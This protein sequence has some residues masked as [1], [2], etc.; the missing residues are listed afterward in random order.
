MHQLLINDLTIDVVR[1]SIKN[2]HLS[3]YP[4]TGR[5]R[6]AAPLNVDDESVRLF[7]LAKLGW[8]KRHQRNF[9]AQARQSLRNYVNRESHYFQGKRYLLRVN[10]IQKG[11]AK[12]AIKN[13]TFMDLYVRPDAAAEQKEQLVNAW[14]RNSLKVQ[15]TQLIAKWEPILGVSVAAWGIKQ[16]KT[17]WGTCNIAERRIWLNLELAK[18]PLTC[19]E[20][21]IV[22]EM[23]HLLE[24]K[25]NDIFWAHLE[26]A[27]PRWK[28]YQE[29]LNALP[30][31]HGEWTY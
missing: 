9:E 25:H 20:Y 8:I 29:E 15:V 12:V 30:V 23:V 14:Y 13:K 1:K 10:E 16:M 31:S 6:I 4:P 17:K 11:A 18:K 28:Y 21:I 5:V 27:M 2:M 3:V 26:K 7:A 22:H 19:V 24:R